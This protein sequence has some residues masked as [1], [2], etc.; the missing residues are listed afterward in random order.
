MAIPFLGG[1]TLVGLSAAV[2]T[3]VLTV[4]ETVPVKLFLL[5]MTIVDVCELPYRIVSVEGL[6]EME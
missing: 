3:T 2:I 1:E 5:V 6:A 4:S